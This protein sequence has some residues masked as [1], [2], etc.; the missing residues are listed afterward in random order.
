LLLSKAD[1]KMR[2][3]EVSYAFTVLT[4]NS[5]PGLTKQLRALRRDIFKGRNSEID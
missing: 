3:K 1:A 2:N 4:R 5:H